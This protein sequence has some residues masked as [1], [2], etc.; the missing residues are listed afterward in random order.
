MKKI[1]NRTDQVVEQMVEGIVKSHPDLIERIPNTRVIARTDKG[2]GKVGLVSG[3]GSGHEPAHAG[4]VGRGMLSAAVCGDVFTSPTPDQIHEGI[5]AANQG[6]GVL[7]IVKNYTGDV[8]NFDMAKE[9]AEMDDIEVD[10]I[11]IDDDISVEDSTFTTGRRGVAG[12]VLVHKIVGAAAEAGASLQELKALGEK[13]VKSIKTIGVAL[14]PCTVPEVGHPGFELGPDEIELGIGIHGEPGFS[15]EKIM[16]SKD[17]A[18]QLFDRI[19]KE[20]HFI[21]GDKVVVLVNGMGGTPL[22]E[23]YIF[24]NDVHE[25][26][27]AAHVDVEKTIVGDYMTSLEMA[28]LSLTI[29]KLEDE[30]W[31]DMLNIPVQTIAWK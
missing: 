30:R 28:G 10:Q 1:I 17:L 12:T 7:L 6:K 23:Q 31:V 24:A 29:L 11:I 14:T 18:K 19:N 15:R 13:V 16:P 21:S 22:M 2:P 25:L 5:K 8:M 27:G 26:L 9:L 4:Y 20:H 3:G